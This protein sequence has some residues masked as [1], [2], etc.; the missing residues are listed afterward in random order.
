MQ[1]NITLFIQIVNFAFTYLFL[2]VLIL[3][4]AVLVLQ[5]RD[6]VHS[7]LRKGI[8]QKE[9]YLKKLV[10]K[11]SEQLS[12]FQSYLKEEYTIPSL[13]VKEVPLRLSYQREEAAIRELVDQG[14]NLII[15]KAFHAY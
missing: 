13:E 7:R 5:R 12:K 2:R 6:F 14:K 8:K 10:V 4:P 11:K 1:I 3:K 9:E 15:E